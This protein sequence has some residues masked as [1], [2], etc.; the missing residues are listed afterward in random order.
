M[1]TL[2]AVFALNAG[3]SIILR[4]DAWLS[5]MRLAW[6]LEHELPGLEQLLERKTSSAEAEAVLGEVALIGS[7]YRFEFFDR[8]GALSF[9]TGSYHAP[10]AD[11]PF[12]LHHVHSHAAVHSSA[13]VDRP[14]LLDAIGANGP[15]P[16]DS[17]TPVLEDRSPVR[18]GGH[19][20][21]LR[22]GDGQTNPLFFAEIVHPIENDGSTLTGTIRLLVDQSDR[23][24]L[25][26]TVLYGATF[27]VVVLIAVGLSLPTHFYLNTMRAKRKADSH[28]EFLAHHD[29]LTG[30]ANRNTFATRLRDRLDFGHADAHHIAAVHFIDIDGFKELNDTLGHDIGDASLKM[31]A[32]QLDDLKS[33]ESFAARLGGDEFAII[34]DGLTDE[35]EADAFAASIVDRF[36]APLSLGEYTVRATVSV[37][38]TLFPTDGASVASLSKNADL[39]LYQAK[40]AGRNTWRRFEPWMDSDLASRRR[41]ETL[42]RQAVANQS[43]ELNYQPLYGADGIAIV[44]FEALLRLPDEKG[45]LI[46]PAQLIPVAERM[47]LMSDIGN[48]V[49]NRACEFAAKWPDDLS[50]AVNLSAGHFQSA[51]LV[52]TVKDALKKTGLAAHRLE[53]EITEAMLIH[54]A[55]GVL[56]QLS[57]LKGLGIS[58]VMDDF[59]TG[60]SSLGYLWKFPFDKIKIDGSF[61]QALESDRE[62]AGEFLR[63]IIALAQTMN[64]KVTAEGVETAGQASWLRDANCNELQGFLFGHPMSEYE[65]AGWLLNSFKNTAGFQDDVPADGQAES[66]VVKLPT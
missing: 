2:G 20:V 10:V 49:I 7:A 23:A 18:A 39:A 34:Q 42:V 66:K 38:T 33:G 13:N 9:S 46:P 61:I 43:F 63:T 27:A 3:A 41:L 24:I 57:E 45:E 47:G 26:R 4:Q 62:R 29:P 64:M 1:A 6:Y 50:V 14:T 32:S 59:G 11:R 44:G 60:F 48:W 19:R 65:T 53:L 17:L 28:I 5:G 8:D 52:A 51:E 15:S 30:L 36:S 21:L 56:N 22:R 54:D 12:G 25:L 58:M 31:V 37:G 35:A 16:S 40:S 55:K